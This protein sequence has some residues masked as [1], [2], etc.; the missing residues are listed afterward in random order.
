[1]SSFKRHGRFQNL[2]LAKINLLNLKK[3]Q[4]TVSQCKASLIVASS[5]KMVKSFNKQQPISVGADG[6]IA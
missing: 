6:D 5:A 1:L 4:K 2:D 3:A